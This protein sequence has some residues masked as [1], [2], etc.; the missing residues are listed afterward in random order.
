MSDARPLIRLNPGAGKRLRAGAPWVFSNEIAMQP[1]H[2]RLPRGGLVRLEGDDGARLG[3]FMF[4]PH[5]LIACRLLTFRPRPIDVAFFPDE[6]PP[7]ITLIAMLCWPD[8][9]VRKRFP[10]VAGRTVLRGMITALTER[11][12]A[13][14]LERTP[15]SCELTLR[16]R[17]PGFDAPDFDGLERA[18]RNPAY[19]AAP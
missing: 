3:T 2:R 7:S 1:E 16:T 8:F 14:S 15:R 9:S 6:S 12:V 4:N 13:A 10:L 11:P 19:S 17:I 5:S 18:F